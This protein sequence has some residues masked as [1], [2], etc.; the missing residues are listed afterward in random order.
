MP[1]K[2]SKVSGL[3]LTI[4]VIL[5]LCVGT[6]VKVKMFNNSYKIHTSLAS[7]IAVK[8]SNCIITI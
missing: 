6:G 7:I 8:F 2:R 1:S 5:I 4:K 3:T